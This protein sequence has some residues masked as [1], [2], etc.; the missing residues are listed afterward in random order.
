MHERIRTLDRD[1][2]PTRRAPR[3]LHRPLRA[4]LLSLLLAGALGA[5]DP[6]DPLADLLG[7]PTAGADAAGDPPASPTS[8]AE[9][10]LSLWTLDDLRQ[11]VRIEVDG[12]LRPDGIVEAIKVVVEAPDDTEEVKG[13]LASIDLENRLL[14]VPPFTIR[15]DDATDIDDEDEEDSYDFEELQPGWHLEVDLVMQD[16][17]SLLA[18]EIAVDKVVN[19]D[20]IGIIEIEAFIDEITGSAD[21]GNMVIVVLG[22]RCRVRQD[23]EFA[24]RDDARGSQS[25]YRDSD[26]EDGGR[27]TF[28]FRPWGTRLIVGGELQLSSELRDQFELDAD[29]DRDISTVD[30]QLTLEARW[31]IDTNLLLYAKG[32]TSRDAV[33]FDQDRD[34]D[35]GEDT[36]LTEAF[37]L[38]DLPDLPFSVQAGRQRF[39]DA[40]EWLYDAELDGGRIAWAHEGWQAEYSYSELIADD[41]GFEDLSYQLFRLRY[42]YAR[43]SAVAFHIVD[44]RDDSLA[45]QSPFYFGL[46]TVG[47]WKGDEH[48][49]RYWA[50][51]AFA[52]G[53]TGVEKLEA[54]ALDVGGAVQWRRAPYEPYLFAGY[55]WGSGDDDP[56]DGI[57]REFRQSGLQ[58]N[59]DKVFGVASYRYYGEMFR[60]ELSNME[61]WTLGVGL[62]PNDLWSVDLV[63]HRYAQDVA[64]TTIRESRLRRSPLGLDRD[65]GTEVDLVIGASGLWGAWGL[66]IDFGH[67]MPGDAFGP[68]DDPATWVAAKI[69]Y[70]F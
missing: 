35:G 24:I 55:A 10:D 9:P 48:Y 30:L 34:L 59:N 63:F 52:D 21:E 3:A 2:L 12:R 57:N 43:R 36:R 7:D 68:F 11:D 26:P 28:R 19:D 5:Q 42:E 45:D 17:G 56:D 64:A 27:G 25:V 31:T 33:I 1:P 66:E 18:V 60:P 46:T 14:V 44:V 70:K 23:T 67:F 40:K 58:D 8:G 39:D 29:V 22:Q 62:R 50:Q 38:Y 65:L 54:H 61:I 4:A 51:Y 32:A 15:V 53:V 49:L 69:E 20:K 41:R 47:R 16:D 37:L 6:A 13:T